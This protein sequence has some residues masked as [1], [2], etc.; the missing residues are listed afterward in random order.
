MKHSIYIFIIILIL[1]MLPFETVYSAGGKI[2]IIVNKNNY[3]SIS[4]YDIQ[5]IYLGNKTSWGSGKI[6]VLDQ[7]SN[8]IRN[9]FYSTI[10]DY[11]PN[12]FDSYWVDEGVRGKGSAPKKLTSSRVV[13]NIVSN[14]VNAI[15]FIWASEADSSV[16]VIATY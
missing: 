13:K 10:L 16:K 3:E 9:S 12:D 11:S 6:V 5:N 2:A 7:R 15:G 8:Q 1:I 14:S 4:F